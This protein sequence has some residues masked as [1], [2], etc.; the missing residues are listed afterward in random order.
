MV[1]SG[2]EDYSTMAAAEPVRPPWEALN[3]KTLLV[4]IPLN[5]L[6]LSYIPLMAGCALT[7]THNDQISYSY[8]PDPN[9]AGCALT[10]TNNLLT[11]S[12]IP[13]LQLLT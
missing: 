7:C 2:S 12:P 11:K 6:A 4:L 9:L 1:Y 5:Q 8:S 10:C 13:S 3:D